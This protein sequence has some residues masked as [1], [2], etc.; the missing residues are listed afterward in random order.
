V[1]VDAARRLMRR[2][3]RFSLELPGAWSDTPWGEERVTKVGA[4]IF[5]FWGSD[6]SPGLT[7]K[8]P[9]SNDHGLRF[10]GATPSNYGLGRHGW[11]TIPL[12]GVAGSDAE[13]LLDFVEESYRAVAPKKLV[14]E[15]D[16]R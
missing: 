11:V 9:E 4:K 16:T 5:A 6:D 10:R 15:L 14:R 13:I 2:L 7:V 1:E 8:L 3:E 12:R